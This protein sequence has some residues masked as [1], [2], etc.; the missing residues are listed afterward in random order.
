MRDKFH[1]TALRR[2]TAMGFDFSQVACRSLVTYL[3]SFCV[4]FGGA[5]AAADPGPLLAALKSPLILRGDGHTAYRDP[6]VFREGDTFYLFYSYVR[7]EEDQLIYWYVAFSKSKD[8]VNWTEP[9]IVTP[10]GQDLN[11]ASP[12]N[13]FKVG[14]EWLMG[15]QTYPIPYF[16][17]GDK[18]RFNNDRARLW[19]FHGKDLENW[20]N[21][22]L[23]KVKG[24]SVEEAELGKMIDP[25]FLR[26][27]DVPGKWWCF[28]KQAGYIHCSWS[29]DLKN[30]SMGTTN[31]A[32]GENEQVFVDDNHEYVMIYSPA[33]GIGL[34]RSTDL[35]HWREGETILLGQKDWP[36]C[37]TRLTGGYV[38]DFR[39]VPGVGKYVM[40]C[41]SMGP[42]KTKTDA[43]VNA[44]CHILIAWSDDLKT[45]SWP[46]KGA[47]P[48]IPSD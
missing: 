10:K 44:N 36:W 9:K 39:T 37:E 31:I 22:E 48:T 21:R 43:N 2:V 3:V 35:V 16:R 7:E 12:G 18:L 27:R 45:W 33:N 25:F 29:N 6:L 13:V 11:F 47:T 28:F 42:G 34:K 41:H 5:A 46:G 1:F 17:R 20:G 26:D 40:V 24:P 23:I 32:F 30:W 8:L 15:A 4:V 38:A 14:D 19:L